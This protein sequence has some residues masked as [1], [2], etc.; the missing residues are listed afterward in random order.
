MSVIKENIKKK[1]GDKIKK[2]SKFQLLLQ[3]QSVGTVSLRPLH[4]C[5]RPSRSHLFSAI[6][7][8]THVNF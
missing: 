2:K 8:L 6:F 4:F 7:M 5:L 3:M 1:T